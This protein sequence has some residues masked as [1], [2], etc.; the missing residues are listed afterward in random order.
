[1]QSLNRWLYG[2]TPEEKVKKWKQT[3]RTQ[4]RQLDREINNVSACPD[5]FRV[6]R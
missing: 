4:E 1:M 5:R 3:L 6:V 2:P